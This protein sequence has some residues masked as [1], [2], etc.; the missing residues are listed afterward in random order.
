MPTAIARYF[1]QAKAET[2]RLVENA[3]AVIPDDGFHAALEM[4]G[5]YG[6]ESTFEEV[7]RIIL[8]W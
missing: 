5:W 3:V 2:E 1:I 7:R 8:S 4:A 6:S